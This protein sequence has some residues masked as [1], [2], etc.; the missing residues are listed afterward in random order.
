MG[1]MTPPARQRLPAT[2]GVAWIDPDEGR[3][4]KP[5]VRVFVAAANREVG[6]R[7]VRIHRRRACAVHQISDRQR[8]GRVDGGRE[9]RHVVHGARPVVHMCEQQHSECTVQP[10]QQGG[11]FNQLQREA[12]LAT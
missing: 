11:G 3:C 2:I 1:L 9:R 4:A 8:A 5:T 10:L 12:A 7:L 6:L